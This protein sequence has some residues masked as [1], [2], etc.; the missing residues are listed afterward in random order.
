VRPGDQIRTN[1]DGA[2]SVADLTTALEV[3]HLIHLSTLFVGGS[4]SKPFTERDLDR[5]QVFRCAYERS[6]WEGER[7]LR[8]W[9]EDTRTRLSVVRP[10][11][12]VGC[13]ATGATLTFPHLYGFLRAFHR[14]LAHRSPGDVLTVPLAADAALPL[15]CGD[16]V[17]EVVENL[18]TSRVESNASNDGETLHLFDPEGPSLGDL[19]TAMSGFNCED[20]IDFQ[21][22]ANPSEIVPPSTARAL[23]AWIQGHLPYLS[24][25]GQFECAQTLSWARERDLHPPRLDW[26][27][28]GRLRGFWESET[29]PMELKVPA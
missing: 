26:A 16:W 19:C 11:I 23:W 5:G 8:Q 7:R 13:S 25:S 3:P 24:A 29:Q 6:K 28:L 14:Y 18:T 2:L 1:V 15:V 21:P 10:G 27:V 9:A 4:H 22:D 12:V 17:S 20:W